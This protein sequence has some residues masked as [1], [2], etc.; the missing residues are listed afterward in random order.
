MLSRTATYM[1][2]LLLIVGVLYFYIHYEQLPETVPLHFNAKGEA[3]AYGNKALLWLFFSIMAFVM[4]VLTLV[5]RADPSVLN[6]PKKYKV[7]KMN[8]VHSISIELLSIVQLWIGGLTLLMSRK[9]ILAAESGQI[10]S[11]YSFWLYI[12]FLL[13][14]ILVYVVRLRKF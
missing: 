8:Q 10:K 12:V 4:F 3:D 14:I 13:T 7:D 2:I 1:S 6:Y 9:I 5:K 11:M